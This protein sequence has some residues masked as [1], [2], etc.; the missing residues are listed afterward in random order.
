MLLNFYIHPWIFLTFLQR[1]EVKNKKI[2]GSISNI[3]FNTAMTFQFIKKKSPAQKRLTILPTQYYESF[4]K[5]Y[6][7][8][9]R[10]SVAGAILQTALSFTDWF[11]WWSF[12]SKSYY[13]HDRDAEVERV[14][15]PS[16]KTLQLKWAIR[17]FKR[18]IIVNKIWFSKH[19]PSG[20][21]LSISRN[22][23]LSVRLS[24]CLSV[25]FWGTA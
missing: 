1:E 8:I 9:N 25:H 21:M 6:I 23:R 10:P 16:L 13:L 11:I 12:S 2:K 5:G 15:P 7:I 24:V 14:A 22:V 20:P 18:V 3:R 17:K 4:F 19:R